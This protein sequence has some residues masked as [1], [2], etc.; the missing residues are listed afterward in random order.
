M[1]I[2]ADL[3]QQEMITTMDAKSMHCLR[4]VASFL[5]MMSSLRPGAL[6]KEYLD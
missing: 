3:Q 2:A 4:Q 5:P 6:P 1:E